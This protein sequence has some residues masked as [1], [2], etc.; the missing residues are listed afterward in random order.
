MKALMV[1]PNLPQGFWSFDR[2]NRLLGTKALSASLGII[3]VAAMLPHNWEIRYVDRVFQEIDGDR[4]DW[5]EIVMISGNIIHGRDMLNLVAEAKR[6]G[7]PVVVGG[8]Y[9]TSV[10]RDLIEAGADFLVRG[11]AESSL[12]PFLDALANGAKTGVFE[13]PAKPDMN[14]SP[15]P[16]FDL[17]DLNSYITM[18][19]QTSR[20]CPFECEFCDVINRYG[21]K[22][23]YKT[24][25]QVITELETLYRLGWRGVVM[26]SDDNF[27]G[28]KTHARAVLAELIPWMEGHGHPFGFVTQTS[29]NLGQ[30][31]ELIDLMTA[32]N[33]GSVFIG[34]ETP[35]VAVLG[36]SRK[37]QNLRHPMVDSI[38]AINKNGLN[39]WGSFILGM[40]GEQKGAGDRVRE[41]V[42][43]T[44]IP[45]VMLNLLQASPNT[46]L[47]HR[48]ERENRL[49]TNRIDDMIATGEVNYIPTRPIEEILKEY[50]DVADRL[51]DPT[52]YLERAY[53]YCLEMRPTRRAMALKAGRKLP[54]ES[55]A[56]KLPLRLAIRNFRA[57]MKLIW[58]QG[59]AAPYRAQ[60]WRQ[61]VGIYRN[62]PSRIVSYLNALG[63][64]ENLFLLRELVRERFG[65]GD[66]TPTHRLQR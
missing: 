49:T 42:E 61:L 5:A 26:I 9:P 22:P 51:Y 40:D 32:A 12:G 47:W 36:A 60:F 43:Q 18:Q 39:V 34:I 46:A 28:S 27:I 29:I 2:S 48:L 3:T 20:G 19:V 31:L 13:E 8:P 1:S 57:L 6:R 55:S 63:E 66:S 54:R 16:R 44:H 62:N 23:R 14:L 53:R 4:W 17:L 38:R 56:G 65:T 11:E 21:R 33:F 45:L 7:K 24:P 64:G 50:V 37:F 41:F 35:D 10:P 15:V 59:I 30:D 58:S 52:A 25:K